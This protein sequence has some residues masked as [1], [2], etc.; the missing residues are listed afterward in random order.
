MEKQDVSQLTEFP[1]FE[2]EPAHSGVITFFNKLLKL[3]LFTSGE[4]ADNAQSNQTNNDTKEEQIQDQAKEV[5]EEVKSEVENYSIELDGRSLPNV[6]KRISNLVAVGSG[7][8]L[9]L[10]RKHHCRVCGVI[11]CSRCCSQRVPGQIFNCA[12]GL[13]VCNYCCNIVLSYLREKDMT[14][15]ISPDLRTLQENLQVKFPEN[16]LSAQNKAKDNFMFA[17]QQDDR[18]DVRPT[19]KEALQDVFRQLSFTLP[20]QQHRYRL[21]RY[22][23]V[24]RGCDILQWI[25][26]NTNNK[27]RAQAAQICQILLNEGYMECVTELPKFA[28]YALYKPINIP[29]I[30][31]DEDS[32]HTETK[33]LCKEVAES[34]EDHLKLLMRQ[35]L[36]RE[37]LSCGWLDILLP[38]CQHAADVTTPDVYSNDIDVRNY[39]QVKKV[40]GGT[41]RDSRWV[42]GIILTK[43][44]AHRNMPQELQNP[45]VLLLDCPIAYQR[46]EGKL[47]SLEPLLM[48]EQE[49]LSRCAARISALHPKVVLVRG[50]AARA[51][52]DALRAEGVALA[53]NVREAALRR[54]ARC[55]RADIVTS[56][57]A[58]IDSSKTLMVLEGCAEPQLGCSILLRGSSLQELIRVKRVVKFML[59]ACYNWKLERSFLKDIEAIL[60]EP[61]MGFD[62]HCTE[63]PDTTEKN[64][65][66]KSVES[67][68]DK[69]DTNDP[70][71]MPEPKSYVRKIDSD[72]TLSCGIPI[73]DNSDPLRARQL[74]I[75]DEVF[76]PSEDTKLKA[77]NHDDRWSTDDTVLSMSPNVVIPAPYL[78][79]EAGRKCPL[80]HY[81]HD[82]LFPPPRQRAV[83]TPK[84]LRRKISKHSE[85]DQIYFK[86]LHP[87]LTKPITTS[88]DDVE[89]KALLANFR[90]TGCRVVASV[91]R[92]GY[93][94][95]IDFHMVRS[96]GPSI[97]HV[98][99]GKASSS[100][101]VVIGKEVCDI[102]TSV[103][104]SYSASSSSRTTQRT[105]LPRSVR[106]HVFSIWRLTV[107]R[108][109]PVVGAARESLPSNGGRVNQAEC[110]VYKPCFLRKSPQKEAE[111]D[112]AADKQGE[113][114]DPLAPENHQKLSLLWYS[115]SNKSPN[116]P[117]FCVNPW[118]ATMEMYG[119][120]DISLG[121]FLD[122]F[123]FNEDYKCSSTNCHIPMNQ[124]VRRF[125][126]GDGCVTVTC[127]T[128]G[129]S[130]A[131]A[132]DEEQSQQIMFWSRCSEC[133]ASSHACHLS[134]C[135]LSLSLAKY[136]ELRIRALRYQSAASC[137][138]P[139]HA[140]AHYFA[141]GLTTAC[142]R[143]NKI[144]MWDIELPPA[145]ISTAYN[146]HEIREELIAQV[147]DLMLKGNATP[148]EVENIILGD[149]QDDSADNEDSDVCSD[150]VDSSDDSESSLESDYE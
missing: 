6:L 1:R 20:T 15:E 30:I 66:T 134:R 98:T 7:Q 113:P 64:L 25:M 41:M 149:S 23:S 79:T 137:H 33:I 36:A 3:P 107:W 95:T 52:Q 12:G 105:F 141:K 120:Q 84:T 139:I 143:Y 127:N 91:H 80:R 24:W 21:V 17:R 140:H 131:D 16:K 85:D 61:G 126:H 40:P 104:S 125:V 45:S 116:V 74:S 34:G 101:A 109:S 76:L 96:L 58:R 117:D 22:N 28:D 72:K 103:S 13:R 63:D 31:P 14:G 83:L 35:C 132:T 115:Y 62:E 150:E 144:T 46:V 108:A 119:R 54:V 75:D 147:N 97:N 4:T 142:F 114:P 2:S 44:V 8:D 39:V 90:A 111:F 87:F 99:T 130:S 42:P 77:D 146:M 118:I 128:I 123:C 56:I 38:L 9:V 100:L 37:N 112:Q 29:P 89:L 71:Q 106:I 47:T 121:A 68:N 11:F 145:V 59:L 94:E 129:H 133:S 48:Q 50:S 82:P 93:A 69:A 43:N 18:V 19:P 148:L 49:Y 10:R 57:D 65:D 32:P 110:P 92:Q 53:T 86:D 78:E 138:H 70:L 124:H 81:F 102:L 122:K 5:C 88:A 135:S 60:P 136:L 67:L 73:R 51:V 27:T 26:D 55:V